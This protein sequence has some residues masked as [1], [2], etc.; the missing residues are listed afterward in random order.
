MATVLAG[1]LALSL[2]SAAVDAPFGGLKQ[3]KVPTA[4][5]QPRAIANGP[6]GEPIARATQLRR[7]DS[8]SRH[9]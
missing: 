8:R 2:G 7:E 3:F 9:S 4:N 1:G 5:S 6:Q